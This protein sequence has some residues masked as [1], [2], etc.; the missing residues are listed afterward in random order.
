MNLLLLSQNL[1]AVPLAI[2]SPAHIGFIPTAASHDPNPWY[3]DDSRQR[4]LELGHHL[5]RLDLDHLSQFEITARLDAVD[6]VFV[7][8][9]NVFYLMQQFQRKNLAAELTARIRHGLPYLGM[10]AGAAVLGP[11]LLP[12]MPMDDPA[13]A[14]HLRDSAGLGL[15]PFVPLPH[16]DNPK[17]VARFESIQAKYGSRHQLLPFRDN[18]AVHVG[19]DGQ[20][21]I[22]DSP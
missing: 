1:G 14:P 22:I 9:G 12:L 2:P 19:A 4:L 17:F 11:S 5:M 18:Q 15:V 10:G 21:R 6:A 16:A 8:A 13:L 3:V 20:P 7:T